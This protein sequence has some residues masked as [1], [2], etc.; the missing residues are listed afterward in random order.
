MLGCYMIIQRSSVTRFEVT[1][2]IWVIASW[3]GMIILF[4]EL[5]FGPGF[6]KTH[7]WNVS[8]YELPKPFYSKFHLLNIH[9]NSKTFWGSTCKKTITSKIM[10]WNRVI[11]NSTAGLLVAWLD[12]SYQLNTCIPHIVAQLII[13]KFCTANN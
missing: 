5:D 6:Y 10:I 9:L 7:L 1:L 2:V 8:K 3:Y 12:H 4:L 11:E 13:N